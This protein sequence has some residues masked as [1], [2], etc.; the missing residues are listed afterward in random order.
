MNQEGSEKRR[1]VRANFPCKIV[2]HT[3]EEKAIAS[4]TENIGAGGIRVIIEDNLKISSVVG[5]EIYLGQEAIVCEGRIVWVVAKKI[6][7]KQ[8]VLHHDTG[9][10]FYKIKEEDRDI[11][12]N[13][14]KAI[15][16]DKK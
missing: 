15:S 4:H 5:L 13:L 3:P 10:E 9:I 6:L 12:N 14:V 16:T 8:E 7:E 1:F 2:I 11:I